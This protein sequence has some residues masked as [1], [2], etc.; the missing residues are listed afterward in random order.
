M[1]ILVSERMF[2]ERLEL[3]NFKEYAKLVAKTY[4]EAPVHEPNA[5]RHWKALVASNNT[6]FRRLLSKVEIIFVSEGQYV[7][8]VGQVCY[9]E[10]FGGFPTQKV[11][12][13]KGFDYYNIGKL[14][15]YGI[16]NKELKP[17]NPDSQG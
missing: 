15:G 9:H 6:L 13:L 5:T 3:K 10:V 16:Q 1:K 4:N 2:K 11:A 17:Q 12:I 14:D 7:E 8:V